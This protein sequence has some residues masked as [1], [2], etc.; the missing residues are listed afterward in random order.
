MEEEIVGIVPHLLQSTG[1]IGS[2][3]FTMIITNQRLIIAQFTIQMM[4]EAMVQSKNKG[5]KG[6]LG[7]LLAGK[8]LTPGDI[9]DYTDKYWSIAPEQ[10]IAEDPSNFSLDIPSISV[11][12]VEY[13]RKESKGDDSSIGLYVLTID[14]IYGQYS[15][16][17]D[18]DPQDIDVLRKVLGDKLIGSGRS[19]PV[20][21]VSSKRETDKQ[22]LPIKEETRFCTNCGKKLSSNANFCTKCGK[23]IK[24]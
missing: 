23:A 1:G 3:H 5:G 9:V 21:P 11:V 4:N 14:S 6:F 22:T 20:K 13:Q 16:I 2:K 12:K 10:I 15:F 7:G 24:V 19:H 17:F 8:V 18:A